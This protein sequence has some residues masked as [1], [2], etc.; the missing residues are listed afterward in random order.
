MSKALNTRQLW[1]PFNDPVLD[2]QAAFRQIMRALAEPGNLTDLSGIYP[3]KDQLSSG[4]LNPLSAAFVVALT[5]LDQDTPV[6]LSPVMSQGELATNLR[7][8]CDAPIVDAPKA[9]SFAFLSLEELESLEP[10][11]P[12]SETHPYQ[13]G[14]LIVEVPGLASLPSQASSYGMILSGP[15]IADS[16]KIAIDSIKPQQIHLLQQNHE[17]FPLGCDFLFTCGSALMAI[18]R[19]TD[20]QAGEQGEN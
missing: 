19:S 11:N 10:F 14:T 12:G 16:R 1:R 17:R 3:G 4:M 18:S 7:F 8:H 6:W 20:L 15:G 9:A 13:S 5:L 2:A